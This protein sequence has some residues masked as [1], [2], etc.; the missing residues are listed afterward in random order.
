MNT[1]VAANKGQIDIAWGERR[2]VAELRRN[3]RRGLRIDVQPTAYVVVFAPQDADIDKIWARVRRKASWIFREIDRIAGYPVTTPERQFLSGE[4]HLLL[5]KQ[6]R[7][8]V[9]H[10]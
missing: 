2:T 1:A 6:Y 10:D 9:G 7:L 4:T 3:T 5:G 8:S